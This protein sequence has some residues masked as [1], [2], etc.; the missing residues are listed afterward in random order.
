MTRTSELRDRARQVLL[1]GLTGAGLEASEA[2]EDRWMT[3]L[4]G[5]WKRTIPVLFHLE[6]RSLT[7][8][9]LFSGVPDEGHAEVY[10][11]LLHRN[12]RSGP[13]HFALDDEGDLILTGD[14]PLAALDARMLDE[15][16]GSILSL[17][18]QTF[19]QVLRTGFATYLEGEQRWRAGAGMPPNPVGDPIRGDGQAPAGPGQP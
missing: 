1:D 19:N 9:S 12:Q 16:L 14:V 10:R 5:E 11:I 6:D 2:G 13:V 18:D 15:V 4:A 8:T 3:M 7:F 17:A